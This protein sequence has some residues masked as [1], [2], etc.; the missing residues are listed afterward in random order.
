[1][2]TSFVSDTTYSVKYTGIE[3]GHVAYES[4]NGIFMCSQ[5]KRSFSILVDQ[6]N[7]YIWKRSYR[8]E[9]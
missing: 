4:E 9:S 7:G 5:I 3:V 6:Q 1:M 8:R 2:V